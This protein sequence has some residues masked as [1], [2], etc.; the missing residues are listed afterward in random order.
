MVWKETCA[1]D[2]RMRFVLAVLDGEEPLSWL[3][4]TYG[5]SRPT[6]YKWLERYRADGP[7]GLL[8]R[9]HAPLRHGRARPRE[10]VRTVLSLR[11]R[12]PRFGPRKL[13]VKLQE[14]LPDIDLPALSTIATWLGKEGLTSR[15]RPRRRCPR[16]EQPFIQVKAPNDVWSVDFKGWFRTGDGTRCDPLTV[17]DAYSRYVLRCE[18]VA[19]PDY[20]H[21]KPILERVFCDHGLPYAIRSDNGPPFASVCA[22]G[23]SQLS[24]WWTKLGI[25]S[26]RIEPGKPEQNGRHE[27]MHRT[28]KAETAAPPASNIAEQQQRFDRFCQMFNEERPHEALKM[29]TPGAVYQRSSRAYPCPLHEPAYPDGFNV[30]RVRTNGTIKWRGELVFVSQ[31]IKG[32]PVGISETESGAWEVRFADIRLGYIDPERGSLYRN[33]PPA[34]P[35]RQAQRASGR[36]NV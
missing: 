27:R 4:E 21:V 35:K 8:D 34:A 24:V 12:Y 1:M 36:Q 20:E 6:G 9:S 17:S 29:K 33:G 19:R 25:A 18:A 28:L 15:Q 10:L 16:Y 2:E 7:E 5:I 11:E 30:R 23:L 26:E 22:G 14:A 31:V 32:E 13:R 3:C